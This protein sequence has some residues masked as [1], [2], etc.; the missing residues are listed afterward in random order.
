MGRV[1]VVV[2]ALL[3]VLGGLVFLA[4]KHDDGLI[5]ECRQRTLESLREEAK[6]W[7]VTRLV[8]SRQRAFI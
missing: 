2:I 8:K 6:V 3:G 1:V 5:A 7:I 4:M